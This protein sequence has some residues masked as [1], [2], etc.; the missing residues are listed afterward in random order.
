MRLLLQ[1]PDDVL[2]AVLEHPSQHR[3]GDQGVHLEVDDLAVAQAGG[4]G[5]WFELDAPRQSF[6][7]GSLADAGLA[8]EHHRVGPV[9]VAENFEH[10]LDFLLASE[11]GRQAILLGKHV[12]VCGKLF[13]VRGQLEAFLQAFVTHLDF[14]RPLVQVKHHIR[15]IGAVPRENRCRRAWRRLLEDR[16]DDIHGFHGLLSGPHGAVQGQLQDELG[17]HRHA[18]ARDGERRHTPKVLFGRLEDDVRVEPDVVHDVGEQVPLDLQKGKEQMFIRKQAV[19]AAARLLHR[20]I[21]L[22]DGRLADLAGRDVEVV[23]LHVALRWLRTE[24]NVRQRSAGRGRIGG[25]TSRGY[26]PTGCGRGG[27]NSPA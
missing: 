6:C 5:G 18:E 27:R 8:D 14:P 7:D 16:H 17:G 9:A 21:D 12:Q 24:Q 25:A 11:H 10:L 26:A 3:P 19:I 22:P 1:F 15:R 13:Q 23:N 20:A 2:Q 4:H